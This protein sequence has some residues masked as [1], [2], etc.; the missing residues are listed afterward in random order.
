M[1]T[2]SDCLLSTERLEPD[3]PACLVLIIRLNSSDNR[4][5]NRA[6]RY[7]EGENEDDNGGMPSL[8]DKPSDQR[9][10]AARVLCFLALLKLLCGALR[11][12]CQAPNSPFISF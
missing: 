8:F 7:E 11:K 10:S 6:H 5:K 3:R 4:S 1:G 12:A 2:W 9:Y